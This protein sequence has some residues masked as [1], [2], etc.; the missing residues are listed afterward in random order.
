MSMEYSDAHI[1]SQRRA[2]QAV[3]KFCQDHGYDVQGVDELKACL[4]ALEKKDVRSAVEAYL[5]VPL[6]RMGCFDDWLPP[7]VFNHE[8]PEYARAVFEALI[9]QW[10][11]LMQLSVTKGRE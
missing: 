11:L 5:R 3:V 7:V 9:T 10:N 6:G 2:T 4:K 1:A 8:T